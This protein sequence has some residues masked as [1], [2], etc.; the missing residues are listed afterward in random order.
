MPAAERPSSEMHELPWMMRPTPARASSVFRTCAQQTG[1]AVD[2]LIDA[3]RSPAPLEIENRAYR[4]TLGQAVWIAME[5][6][7]GR[8]LARAEIL[9]LFPMLDEDFSAYGPSVRRSLK[10]N[11][12]KLAAELLVKP[13]GD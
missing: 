7:E 10:A 3:C 5:L 6:V 2:V 4:G 1:D 12:A 11:E 9:D 8:T 13:V